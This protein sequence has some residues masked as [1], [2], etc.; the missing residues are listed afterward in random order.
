MTT[1]TTHHQVTF[2][3]PFSLPG[4]DESWPAGEYTVATDE[5]QL[6]TRFPAFHRVS[7]T[8]ALSKGAVTH[9][10]SIAPLDLAAALDRDRQSGGI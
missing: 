6:D 10:V 5:E 8:I 9:H 1:R 3:N 4:W 2:R 7:T